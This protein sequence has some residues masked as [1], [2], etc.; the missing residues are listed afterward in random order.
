MAQ[1]D[2]VIA[3][4][5]GAAVRSDLNNALAAIVSQNSGATAPS[6]TYAYQW[7]ADTTTNLLKLRNA[8][9]S[10]WITLFQLDGEWSTIALENGTA[11]APSIYF[12][13]SGTDTGFYSPGTDQVGISTGGTARLTIDSNGNVNIDSNTLYVDAANNRVGLGTSSP[14]SRLT[15]NRVNYADASATGATTLSNAGIT[16]EAATDTNNRLMFG[17]GSTGG[18]PWI[19]AQNTSS[20][21]TQSLILNPVGG[22]VG[23]GVTAPTNAR[24]DVRE[25]TNYPI[26]WGSTSAQFGELSY[27]TGNCVIGA[28]SGNKLTLRSAGNAAI[29]IDTSQRV[30]VGTSSSVT[31]TNA[32]YG[33]LQSIGNTFATPGNGIMVL[34]RSE[35][36]TSITDGEGLGAIYFTD[37]AG[38]EF[39][40]ISGIA[41]GTAGTNDYPG[42]L[43][44]STTLDGASSPTERMRLTNQGAIWA[45]SRAG[46]STFGAVT[47]YHGLVQNSGGQW[48]LGLQNNGNEGDSGF[49]LTISYPNTAPNNTGNSFIQAADSTASRF[50]VRSNG[51]IANYSGNNVNLCDEREK[52]NI[53]NLDSTWD[54]LK[55]WELKKFHYN[56]DADTDDLR[57]GVIAQQVAEYCPEVITDWVK[58]EAKDAV[59]D[60]DDN[61]IEPAKEEVVRMG[62]KE[63]QMMWMAIKALQEAQL[64]IETLEAE[65]A[66]LKGA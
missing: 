56:E 3:N 5:T 22:N 46:V 30:L 58:Q 34:G 18:A 9:N 57:Y 63:Q 38:G 48:V 15:V 17:I 1:H 31:G 49:G 21:A 4:G 66:T 41:D 6:T 36:A 44:F 51:G 11:A 23:I 33:R 14:G 28:T 64:R 47:H 26:R 55:H 40:V 53:V 45:A 39:A 12:K 8:A 16:V 19:Q 29:T 62:V 54:C 50:I 13:D 37:N 35:A 42:R 60:N 25:D 20:N 32:Q 7:W 59:L 27:D 61:E 52:K 24:L 10:G 43:T 65:V 2:Y